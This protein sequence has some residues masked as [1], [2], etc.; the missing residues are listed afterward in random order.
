[1]WY[2]FAILVTFLIG[3]RG[4]VRMEAKLE[5]AQESWGGEGGGRSSRNWQKGG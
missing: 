1:M 5:G 2:C 4:E 3:A